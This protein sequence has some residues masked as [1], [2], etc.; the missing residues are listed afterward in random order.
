MKLNNAAAKCCGSPFGSDNHKPLAVAVSSYARKKRRRWP[1]DK[2]QP[3]VTV[4]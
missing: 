1:V 4:M 2:R 3:A